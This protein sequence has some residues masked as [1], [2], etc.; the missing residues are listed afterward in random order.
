MTGCTCPQSPSHWYP[1]GIA[2]TIACDR[3]HRRLI[4]T[5]PNPDP[6]PIG[7]AS[8]VECGRCHRKVLDEP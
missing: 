6:Q 7:W 5:C 4:C 3:A 2:H 8:A 1:D